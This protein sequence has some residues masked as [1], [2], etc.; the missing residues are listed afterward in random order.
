M[1]KTDPSGLK[2]GDTI[3]IK[4]AS[5]ALGGD[6]VSKDRGLPIFVA[7][8][9][10][11]DTIEVELFD[12]RKHFARA[13]ILRVL[14]A[15]PQRTQPP[16]AL[17][18]VCGGCQLQHLE[19]SEQLRT[20]QSFLEQACRHIGGLEETM[21]LPTI[22]AEND[23]FYRNK[24]QFPVR[25]P[26]NSNRLLAGYFKAD[27]HELVN[28]KHCP[29]QPG[30]I[31]QIMEL[32]KTL[33]EESGFQAY[34]ERTHTGLVRHINVRYSFATKKAL[35]TFVINST[36][37]QFF[38]R[39]SRT[40]RHKLEMI[41]KDLMASIEDV[42]GVSVNFNS[43]EGNK[44]LGDEFLS[45]GGEEY[46]EE[47]LS[48]NRENAPQRL[49]SG[50][51]YRLSPGSFFQINSEQA[52]KLFDAVRDAIGD[53]HPKLLVDA[54]AGVG[55][56]ALWLAD[57]AEKVIAVEE[58]PAAVIDGRYN[59]ELN[60]IDNVIFEQ[61]STEKALAEMIK[62]KVTPDVVLVDPPRK[63]LSEEVVQGLLKLNPEK[64]IYVSCN[65]ST[66]ARDLKL[67]ATGQPT[68]LETDVQKADCLGYKAKQVQPVD[69]FPHTHHVESVTILER[70]GHG[71]INLEEAR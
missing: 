12:V 20:K 22:P 37:T 53:A 57:L 28:I 55:A 24:V 41:A 17:F 56:M 1:T 9:A 43:A 60:N 4:V 51:R 33:F 34:D 27:S 71:L 63:G 67:F 40:V 38:S 26:K 59:A 46:I 68:D 11:Q 49:S 23:L 29:V 6:G 39:H 47:I 69:L 70:R 42:A 2:K 44:I 8:A 18:G 16:C 3:Q 32:V 64:I 62:Q 13:K 19:Y 25:N 35:L 15:S 66:L 10:P 54:Y 14:E 50:V 45:I 52:A 21:V 7:Y 36:K 58:H 30:I 31:D 48:S 61:K 65:P 5:V